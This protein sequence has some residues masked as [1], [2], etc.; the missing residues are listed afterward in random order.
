MDGW[1]AVVSIFGSA[2]LITLG[3]MIVIVLAAGFIM[4]G[5]DSIITTTVVALIL[6]GLA[7]YVRAVALN[8]QNA[9]K[10]AETQWHG[11]LGLTMQT[12]LVYAAT[13]AIGIAIIHLIRSI[14]IR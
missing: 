5:F 7:G 8:G 6:F 11:F 10:L 9:A 13:F 4:Q 3:I 12:V 1:N 14:V 2:D